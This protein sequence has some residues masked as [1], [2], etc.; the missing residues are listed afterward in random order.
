MERTYSEQDLWDLICSV[1]SFKELHRVE[2]LV[3]TA[4]FL[5]LDTYDNMMNALAF[6]SRDL[7]R[8]SR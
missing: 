6:I 5:S 8:H 1:D 4:D 2:D 3:A 7:Y